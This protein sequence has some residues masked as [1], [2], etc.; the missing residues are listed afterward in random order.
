[1]TDR[2][3][4][5]RN[6]NF[7]NIT[8]A[9][10]KK[11]AIRIIGLPERPMQGLQF[12]NIVIKASAGIQVQDACNIRFNNMQIVTDQGPAFHFDECSDIKI[13]RDREPEKTELFVELIGKKTANIELYNMPIDAS[14]THH[15]ADWLWRKLHSLGD[16]L[17]QRI[18]QHEHDVEP[19]EMEE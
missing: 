8:C 7:R 12:D 18:K 19:E 5:Y 4:T 2:T 16:A 14:V 15:E 10:A 1:M 13:G 9:Y 17:A 11:A 6:L 3:P